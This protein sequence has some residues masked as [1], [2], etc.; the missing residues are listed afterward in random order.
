MKRVRVGVVGL[1]QWGRHHVRNYHQIPQVD[2]VA[3][4]DLDE[5]E[6]R[7]FSR[8]YQVEGFVDHRA[9]IG[10]V[11]AV[12]IVV[13]TVHHYAVAR[14]FLEA[15]VHV[16]L[17]KPMT[18]TQEEAEELVDLARRRGVLLLVG[19][20]ER[21]KPAVGQFVEMARRPLFIQC[22]RARPFDP[23]RAM[24]VGDVLDLMIHDLDIVLALTGARIA[25][26]SAV[27]ACVHNEDEDLAVV[28]LVLRD[29]C[30]ASL[31][32]SRIAPT[33]VAE[34]EAT[35][36]DR[37]VALDYLRQSISVRRFDG[38]MEHVECRREEPLLE[39]LIHFAECVQGLQTPLVPG[40]AGLQVLAAA[41]QVLGQ[42]TMMRP[43]V[44][45]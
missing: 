12:S 21:F 38:E 7:G 28:H 31:V 17:E 18:T 14:D 9:L 22:R 1:G 13:P 4:A 41:Q 34:I 19:H 43:R 6:V 30:A 33:K 25:R 16:L 11:D 10:R 24:D 32:A 40:E 5:R 23:N 29:G 27:G 42:M 37:V 3:V 20:V 45:A 35:L 2:L 44:M 36:E 8:R 15:G 39:E 26:V